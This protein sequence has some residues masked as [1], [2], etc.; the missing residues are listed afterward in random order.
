MTKSTKDAQNPS[1]NE[2]TVCPHCNKPIDRTYSK[3]I[4]NYCGY[5]RG[6]ISNE[7]KLEVLMNAC[8]AARD[9]PGAV[10]IISD[11]IREI[12]NKYAEK[13][14]CKKLQNPKDVL[15]ILVERYTLDGVSPEQKVKENSVPS[16][17]NTAGSY[18]AQI[19][20]ELRE[21]NM[22]LGGPLPSPDLNNKEKENPT[23]QKRGRGRPRNSI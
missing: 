5:C 16:S 13:S 18:L 3:G 10:L 23:P 7:A 8:F 2:P 12:F 9:F 17:P 20:Q 6:P 4:I 19:V 22:K 15:P 14:G 11:D 1:N 21:I